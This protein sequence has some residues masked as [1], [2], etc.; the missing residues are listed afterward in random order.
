M[1]VSASAARYEPIKLNIDRLLAAFGLAA[2]WPVL[3]LV[4]IAIY[5]DDPGPVLF[6]QKRAGRW[7]RP[8]T[9]YKFRTMR[10]DT[11]DLSTEEMRRTGVTPYTRLG[12]FLRKTSL[13]ELP[14]LFNVMQGEMS[15]VG[16]RPA[17][18]SQEVVLR[19]RENAG[20]H[21]LR[22]GITGLAQITGRDDLADSEKI[23][24]DAIYL[25]KIGLVTDIIVIFYTIRHIFKARGAY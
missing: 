12:P 14:Q 5:I 17:L 7:H 23:K 8:F 11:P 1:S 21:Q 19:G 9:I 4:S 15:L 22:P 20:V 24:K 10:C 25:R 13:D 18:M 16:P 6:R 2:L 3:L